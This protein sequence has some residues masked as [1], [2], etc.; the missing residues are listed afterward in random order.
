MT[1]VSQC[2]NG[3]LMLT[4]RATGITAQLDNG[5]ALTWHPGSNHLRFNVA[6][7]IFFRLEDRT[8]N[9]VHVIREDQTVTSCLDVF[10]GTNCWR[11]SGSKERR[12]CKNAGNSW[13]SN[14]KCQ[15]FFGDR[16]DQSRGS[17]VVKATRRER[18][19]GDSGQGGEK[20]SSNQ[21][22]QSQQSQWGAE[23]LARPSRPFDIAV[24]TQSVGGQLSVTVRVLYSLAMYGGMALAGKFLCDAADVDFFGGFRLD[25]EDFYSALLYAL[26]PIFGSLVLHQ[27]SVGESWSP[28]RAI[29]DAED[30][31]LAD[32][33]VGMSGWQYSLIVMVAVTAEEFFFRSAVQGGLAHALQLSSKGVNETTYGIAAL[34]G[35]IP[36]FGPCSQAMACV[37]TAA[38]T[39]SMFYVISTPKDPKVV[40]A[41]GNPREMR[42]SVEAW[43][44]HQKMKKIYS[45]LLESLLSLYLG[46]EWLATGNLLAPMVTHG[47]YY[48][49]TVGNGMRRLE[50]REKALLKRRLSLLGKVG[51][52]S[53][54]SDSTR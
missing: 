20:E 9:G 45:P 21:L 18:D 31:E 14:D 54:I 29:R 51:E 36:S 40:V 49:S 22:Q 2:S 42:K 6:Q 17:L 24:V 10:H 37:L 28:A 16:E 13:Y 48:I 30:E 46:F 34:T 8:T 44:E 5:V 15:R 50:D 7:H 23:Q 53:R 11:M 1:T 43:H 47:L 33:F 25:A 27:D 12:M 32:F 39:G 35:I 19:N 38:I 41:R 26:L 4:S 3:L 52:K